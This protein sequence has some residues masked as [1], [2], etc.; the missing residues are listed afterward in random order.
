[1]LSRFHRRIEQSWP[2]TG[3]NKERESPSPTCEIARRVEKEPAT[4][5][6]T[7]RHQVEAIGIHCQACDGFEVGDHRVDE[8][9]CERERERE[10]LTTHSWGCKPPPP[11]LRQL[12][13]SAGSTLRFRSGFQTTLGKAATWMQRVRTTRTRVKGTPGQRPKRR[14]KARPA[15][16]RWKTNEERNGR[17]RM[18]HPLTDEQSQRK[19]TL[20][21]EPKISRS[22]ES[23]SDW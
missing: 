14:E 23:Y 12:P 17:S 15:P 22:E 5:V 9:A 19:S 7:A 21:L 3:R 10:G 4:E 6:L 13:G 11:N 1:M 20:A 16:L 8:L 18:T 2:G